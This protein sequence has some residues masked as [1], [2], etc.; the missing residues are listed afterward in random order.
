MI[1]EKQEREG[2]TQPCTNTAIRPEARSLFVDYG[3]LWL[4]GLL[5]QKCWSQ[6]V[7]TIRRRSITESNF[8]LPASR[9]HQQQV[10]L[11]KEQWVVCWRKKENEEEF[12]VSWR[13]FFTS[14]HHRRTYRVW[15]CP[16]ICAEDGGFSPD[17]V[18]WKWFQNGTIP[19]PRNGNLWNVVW[20]F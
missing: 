8:S 7:P 4:W 15:G 14:H 11:C 19:R 6:R 1:G 16:R 10:F 12:T 20:E 18:A 5:W 3:E 9:E 2:R 13:T 17:E